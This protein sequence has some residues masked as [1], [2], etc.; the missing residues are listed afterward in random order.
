MKE[1]IRRKL[2]EYVELNELMSTH[3]YADRILKRFYSTKSFPV[4]LATPQKGGLSKEVVGSYILDER[5]K[6]RIM[7]DIADAERSKMPENGEYGIIIHKFDI[8]PTDMEF[9]DREETLRVYRATIMGTSSLYIE[10]P[11]TGSMGDILFMIV[12]D[13]AIKTILYARSF[14]L[15]EKYSSLKDILTMDEVW[16]LE[17][18]E[19]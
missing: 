2:R 1:L 17:R 12:E 9:K 6:N 3:H 18:D 7:S 16:K 15:H 8:D 13:Q 19:N 11:E 5:T 10:D 4:V 14:N